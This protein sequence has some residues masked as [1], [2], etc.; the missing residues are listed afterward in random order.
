LLV[1]PALN[2]MFSSRATS[3]S[4]QRADGRA[5][6]GPTVSVGEGDRASEQLAEPVDDRREG[7]LVLRGA[8][9]P[10]EVG[11]HDDACARLGAGP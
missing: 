7:V 8:L 5:G 4:A 11:A 3:P 1:S 10:T 6:V 2:R 9:G